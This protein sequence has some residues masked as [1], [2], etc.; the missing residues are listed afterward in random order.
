M[1]SIEFLQF[2]QPNEIL[3]LS[4]LCKTA[5]KVF[6]PNAIILDHMSKP[7]IFKE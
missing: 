3:K 4:L 5:R 2:F 7:A 1:M 6:D